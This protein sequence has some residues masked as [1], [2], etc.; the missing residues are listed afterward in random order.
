MVKYLLQ[1]PSSNNS[2]LA[3]NGKAKNVRS[4]HAT[5]CQSDV[6]YLPKVEVAEVLLSK[7]ANGLGGLGH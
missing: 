3:N 1:M 6:R 2:E 4:G 5:S 7:L